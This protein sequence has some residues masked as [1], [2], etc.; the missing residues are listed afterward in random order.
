MPSS[1]LIKQQGKYKGKSKRRQSSDRPKSDESNDRGPSRLST[2]HNDT[3]DFAN[4]NFSDN[5][6]IDDDAFRCRSYLKK[7]LD[8]RY[9]ST[10]HRLD[11]E[12]SNSSACSSLSSDVHLKKSTSSDSLS[13]RNTQTR[14]EPD[15]V[16]V[17]HMQ[18]D[19]IETFRDKYEGSPTKNEVVTQI[20]RSGPRNWGSDCELVSDLRDQLEQTKEGNNINSLQ[21]GRLGSIKS[22]ESK[23]VRSLRD[24]LQ[25][26]QQGSSNHFGL[27]RDGDDALEFSGGT[28]ESICIDMVLH[29]YAA[30][31]EDSDNDKLGTVRIIKTPSGRVGFMRNS[32]NSRSSLVDSCHHDYSKQFVRNN[33][34]VLTWVAVVAG[35]VATICV[36]MMIPLGIISNLREESGEVGGAAYIGHVGSVAESKSGSLL[37]SPSFSY[38]DISLMKDAEKLALA[39]R[40]IHACS[41]SLSETSEH[42]QMLCENKEC[43]FADLEGYVENSTTSSNIQYCGFDVQE[44]CLVFAGCEKWFLQ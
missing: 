41:K 25:S 19:T 31:D 38:E 40:V 20:D 14:L 17:P 44:N 23:T 26:N 28:R 5:H 16:D 42:C 32:T 7:S 33:R 22:V 29:G 37:E 12:S 27:E 21:S 35:L 11:G 1:N 15:H 43:C 36:L 6:L 3:I 2:T 13:T 9:D 24:S 8:S 30:K 39:E 4:L 10:K 34:E 18:V